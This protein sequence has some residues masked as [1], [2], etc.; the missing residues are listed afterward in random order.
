M[1][2][3]D[4]LPYIDLPFVQPENAYHF[5]TDTVL[6]GLFLPRLKNRVV[7]DIGTNCGA[8]LCYAA[9]KEA[10]MLYGAD[11]N[12]TALEYAETNLKELNVPYQLYALDFREIPVSEIDTIIV[13]PPFYPDKERKT[14]VKLL[15]VYVALIVVS[16]IFPLLFTQIISLSVFEKY[17]VSYGSLLDFQFRI[18]R[19]VIRLP[20]YVFELLTFK[21]YQ[22]QDSRFY[23]GIIFMEIIGLF[24]NFYMEWAFRIA[25]YFSFGHVF[26]MCHY[27]SNLQSKSNKLLFHIGFLI[28]YIGYFYAVHVMWEYDEIIPYSID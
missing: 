2:K 5:N 22:D 1:T 19:F 3:S 15:A 14:S 26:Y 20:L 12:T 24:L 8:L 17:A 18:N 23:L 21:K 7:L 4:F 11:L 10:K 9:H 28:Y 27:L 25:Y 6:L 13:N 16:F